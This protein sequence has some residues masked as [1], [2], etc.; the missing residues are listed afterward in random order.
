VADILQRWQQQFPLCFE[1][2]DKDLYGVSCGDGWYP[3]IESLLGG[4]ENHLKAKY[5]AGFR[6]VV[7][8][9]EFPFTIQ[10]IK[11]KFGTLRFYVSGA[12]DTIYRMIVGAETASSI[13]CEAC[14]AP[15]K[16]SRRGAWFRTMC[17][18]CST[19]HGY[20][21]ADEETSDVE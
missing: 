5:E 4:I 14:G 2:Q 21:L 3:I 7:E 9:G 1:S 15:G 19:E 13:T 18:N 10:C 17:T 12:D 11:E 6:P 20:V 16:F 8:N